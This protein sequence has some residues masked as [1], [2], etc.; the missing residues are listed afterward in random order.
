MSRFH[1]LYTGV[2]L[3]A[4][5]AGC[6]RPP[7]PPPVVTQ[8]KPVEFWFGGDVHLG[9]GGK[10]VL[11]KLKPLVGDALGVVNL[12]GA[13][14]EKAADPSKLSLLNSPAALAELSSL[15]IR[16]VGIANNHAGDAGPDGATRTAEAVRAAKFLPA[17][18]PANAAVLKIEGMTFV[19]TAHDLTDG[20]PPGLE[21]DL[22]AA[23]A[24]G[25]V[26]ISMF[27]VTGPTSYLPRPELKTAAETARRA[28]AALIVAH[29][30]HVVGPVERRGASIIA[31]GLGNVAFAC[32]CT[33]EDEAILLRVRFEG[34]KTVGAEVIPIS[35]GLNGAPTAPASDSKG[36]FDL[37]EAI[38]SKG[39]ARNGQLKVD[40]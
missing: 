35:A 12:E 24:R 10:N 28:G 17:G 21:T 9:R 11:S 15:N 25:D 29:G 2:L 4:L 23:R 20:V 40:N 1:H 22:T 3:V 8:V 7:A 16:V 13:V 39:L 18:G 38:G 14:A 5:L 31:W 19:F 26:L 33:K 37:L 34:E 36:M 6:G 27:H 32:D 30:T